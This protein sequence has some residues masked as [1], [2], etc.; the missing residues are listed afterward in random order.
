MS[1]DIER[2]SSCETT[3]QPLAGASYHIARHLVLRV[4]YLVAVGG[5]GGGGGLEVY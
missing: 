5:G 3:Q 1:C 4:S 2:E